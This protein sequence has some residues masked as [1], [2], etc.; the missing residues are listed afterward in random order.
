MN[1]HGHDIPDPDWVSPCGEAILYNADCLDILPKLP[2][3]CVDA[4]VTDPPY[5]ISVAGSKNVSPRGTR[6][7]D[8][9]DGDSDWGKSIAIA[10]RA[11]LICAHIGPHTQCWWL[12]HRQIGAINDTLES[13]SYSTR[14]LAWNK[15]CPAPTAPGAGFASAFEI[16]L[17]GYRPGRAWNG[18]QYEFNRFDADSY[19]NGKPGKV[20]H[21]TQKPIEL[22]AW[23]V[24]LLTNA[25][26]VCLDPFTGSGTTGVACARLGR[27][28]IGIEIEPEYFEI[29]KT[30]ID[31]EL[32]QGKLAFDAGGPN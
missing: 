18:G 8:F 2:D 20:D 1:W 17:Y 9:F 3:G 4:C 25:G 30:R 12:G 31:Q 15:T 14:L 27:K 19:R 5:A 22:L 16:C 32:R 24:R 21:P 13:A 26:E 29:A 7:L 10:Q 11:A 23:Q 28:F 6:N